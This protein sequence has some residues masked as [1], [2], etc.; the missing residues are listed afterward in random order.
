VTKYDVVTPVPVRSSSMAW[1]GNVPFRRV[2]DQLGRDPC[3]PE[4]TAY[5]LSGPLE[6]I[7]CGVHLDRGFRLAFTMQPADESGDHDRPPG[8]EGN[9]PEIDQE[10]LDA[11]VEDLRRMVTPR[12][13][14]P[15]RDVSDRRSQI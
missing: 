9:L 6:P 14:A 2:H 7:V 13:I 1:P 4:L 12:A 10:Q 3:A 11:F 5:R 8:C 15:A